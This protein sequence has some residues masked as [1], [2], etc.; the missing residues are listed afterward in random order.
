MR[1]FVCACCLL[2]LAGICWA[3]DTNFPVGP[4]Y[5]MTFGSP[6][7][8]RPIATPS[9]SFETPLL[10]AGTIEAS[11]VQVPPEEYQPITQILELQRRQYLPSVYWGAPMVSVVEINFREVAEEGSS[12]ALPAS[13][14]ESG[15]IAVTDAQSLRDRG[16]GVTLPEAAQRWKGRKGNAPHVYTNSDIERLRNGS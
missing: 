6:L 15:V 14:I 1:S 5:L 13:I 12:P 16:Y 3:Q 4:Q 9:L 2:V 10:E 8:A 7:L 11:A